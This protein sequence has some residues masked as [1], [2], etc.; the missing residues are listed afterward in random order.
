MEEDG[1]VGH[2]LDG[3]RYDTGD[4][5]GLIEANLAW[6]MKRPELAA[7]LRKTLRQYL[8]D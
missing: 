8:D 7:R 5:G 4:L 6:A 2:L 3:T 1:L